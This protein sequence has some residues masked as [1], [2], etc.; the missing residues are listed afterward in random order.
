MMM[1]MVVIVTA[2]ASANTVKC[3][4]AARCRYPPVT[5]RCRRRWLS[6]LYPAHS[7]R[8]DLGPH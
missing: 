7:L 3:T 6:L 1:M 8:V 4:H 5:P 2:A